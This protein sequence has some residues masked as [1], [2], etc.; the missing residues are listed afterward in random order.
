MQRKHERTA[1]VHD[2]KTPGFAE[3]GIAGPDGR[4]VEFACMKF[5]VLMTNPDDTSFIKN[6]LICREL[7][8][9]QN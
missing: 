4:M 6:Y 1:A 5:D 9:S 2:L 8:I 7:C 3:H